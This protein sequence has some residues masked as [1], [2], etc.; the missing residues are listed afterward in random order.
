MSM[1]RPFNGP[2]VAATPT[3]VT[4]SSDACASPSGSLIS[5]C[6]VTNEAPRDTLMVS[7]LST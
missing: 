4:Q 1:Y 7:R 2:A 6:Y 3:V 5:K